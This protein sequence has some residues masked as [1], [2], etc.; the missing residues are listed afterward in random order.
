M[1]ALANISHGNKN[2]YQGRDNFNPSWAGSTQ[3]PNFRRPAYQSR[4]SGG[5]NRN[6]KDK[7]QRVCDCSPFLKY[8][9]VY[10]ILASTNY[11][12]S[13]DCSDNTTKIKAR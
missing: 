12:A 13:I 7:G 10:M 1:P 8:Y 2:K 9:Y 5:G 11:W 3:A 6:N 4:A